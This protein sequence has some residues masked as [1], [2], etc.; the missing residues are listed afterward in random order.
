MFDVLI[1]LH[2][3]VLIL[4]VKVVGQTSRSQEDNV[5]KVV[6]AILCQCFLVNYSKY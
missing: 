1:H 5:A 2:T 4:K 3:P 6:S